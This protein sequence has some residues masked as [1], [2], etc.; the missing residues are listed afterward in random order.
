VT[1]VTKNNLVTRD[2]DLLAELAGCRAAAVFISVTTLDTELRKILEPRTSPPGARLAT[3]GALAKAGI[4]TGVLVAP[5]IPGLTDHEVPAI[6][7]AAAAAGASFAAQA[8]LRLPYAVAPLFEE[9]LA[10][11]VPEKK[12]KV[13][14]RLRAL[15]RGK[16]NNSEFGLRLRGEGIF[17]EQMA[18]LFQVACRRAGGLDREPELSTAFFR[19]PAGAQL[20]LGLPE[21]GGRAAEGRQTGRWPHGSSTG[22]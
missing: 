21:P 9:W 5:V 2:L 22:S 13:L 6:L 1:V 4:P 8:T 20:E 10:R 14:N 17:A 15:R 12:D 18:R 11:H 3:I 7:E 16:L 19:R